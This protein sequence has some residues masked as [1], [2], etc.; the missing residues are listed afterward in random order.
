MD[1]ILARL[2][3]PTAERARLLLTRGVLSIFQGELPTAIADL[4]ASTE[5]SAD[6]ATTLACALGHTYRCLAFVFSGRHAEA[7]AAGAAAEERLG[8]VGHRSGLV[9]LDIHLGYLHLLS[10]QPDLAIERCAQGLRRLD[11][12]ERW[13]RSYLLVITALGLFLRGEIAA[14]AAPARESLLLKQEVGDLTGIAY[15]LEMLA[16]LAA[17]QQRY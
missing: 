17:V 10:G 14:S 6:A 15:C 4:E 13:A 16:M 1:K 9:S 5:L 8:A 12:G 3:G 11:D 7:V 2:A